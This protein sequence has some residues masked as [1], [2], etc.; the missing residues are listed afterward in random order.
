[1]ATKDSITRL[2]LH[3]GVFFR[4]YGSFVA[5]FHTG[6]RKVFTFNSTSADVF[7][8]FKEFCSIDDALARL[9]T[10]YAAA[11]PDGFNRTIAAFIDQAVDKG[12]L[13]AEYKQSEDRQNLEARISRNLEGTSQL[14]SATIELTYRCNEKCKHCYVINERR[15]E[16]STDECK[17]ILDT[18]AEMGVLN[19]VF[20]GGEVFIRRDSFDILEY[21]Y[22]RGFA[23]DI[24]TNGTLLDSED[25]IRLKGLW[26]RCVHFSVYSHIPEKHDRITKVKGSFEKTLNSIRACALVGIPVNIK[27]IVLQ[28]TV[29]DVAGLVGLA[30]SLGAS[31]EVGR[32]IIP[33][34]N[35]DLS[36][37][38]L[39]VTAP[40]EYNRVSAVLDGLIPEVNCANPG[41]SLE[42]RICGAGEHFISINPYGQVY[43]CNTLPL[44]IGDLSSTSLQQIWSG[45]AALQ[46]W[47]EHNRV[48]GRTGCG[49]CELA[50]QCI[51]CPGEAM[52][53]TGDPLQMYP[54]ACASTRLAVDAHQMSEK[55]GA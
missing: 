16:L 52:L 21:A 26:P 37:T 35:G 41:R 54:D 10:I 5:L 40:N 31:I 4:S 6:V 53:R 46:W 22:A 1:M 7:A 30:E 12:I 24:F 45:S 28:E 43:P 42:D 49:G 51:F 23:M 25:I 44:Q 2:R 48:G 50:S 9:R 47:R 3:P 27:T 34:K 18:L 38:S 39:K 36:V 19:V 55:G 11:D 14:Y 15:P 33:K 20:T 13:Q 17:V 32:G 29:D 8:C